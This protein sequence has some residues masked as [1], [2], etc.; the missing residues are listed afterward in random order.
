MPNLTRLIL[1]ALIA[2]GL[3]PAAEGGTKIRLLTLG[4][5]F[6]GNALSQL[7]PIVKSTANTLEV[8]RCNPGGCSL[9]QHW[10]RIQAGDKDPADPKGQYDNKQ[11]FA[12]NLADGPWDVITIQQYSLISHDAKTYRPYAAD[13]LAYIKERAPTAEVVVHQ[14][15]AYRC[16]DGRFKPDGDVKNQQEMYEGLTRAYTG[17]ASEFGLRI[18]PSGNAFWA[19]DQDP[20]WGYKIDAAF[21]AASAVNP[22]LP[23]QRRSLHV[24][25][26]WKDNKLTKDCH[27]A[28]TPGCYLAGLVWYESLFKQSCLDV[29]YAPKGIDAEYAAFLRQT[30]HAAV[31]AE[32]ARKP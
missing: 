25:Y 3:A 21:D 28:S 22:A 32:Q 2:G 14:T 9:A 27:H 26:R 7:E 11:S 20:T 15:W 8:R 29:T 17:I 10:A 24:G 30:A 12:A 16:D 23:D 18:L 6:A 1:I 31:V 13:I 19:A 5:S 4:N